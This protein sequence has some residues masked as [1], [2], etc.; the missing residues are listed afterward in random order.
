MPEHSTGDTDYHTS[1]IVIGTT[2]VAENG[3][4]VLGRVGGMLNIEFK[5]AP[6]TRT[7]R[8]QRLY[9]WTGTQ[10]RLQRGIRT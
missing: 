6:G 4:M 3:L 1:G 7:F 5:A 10:W 2:P 9:F 8:G